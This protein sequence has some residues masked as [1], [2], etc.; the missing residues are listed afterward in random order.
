[1]KQKIT[2][3]GTFHGFPDGKAQGVPSLFYLLTFTHKGLRI[4]NHLDLLFNQPTFKAFK[5]LKPCTKH[6]PLLVYGLKPPNKHFIL[7][8][9]Q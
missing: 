3:L 1:M 5:T 9:C 6:W 2:H 8:S 4:F 7:W